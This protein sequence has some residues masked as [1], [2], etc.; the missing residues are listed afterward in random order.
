MLLYRKICFPYFLYHNILFFRVI[1][2]SYFHSCTA[3]EHFLFIPL[4]FA[5]TFIFPFLFLY[6]DMFNSGIFH[7]RCVILWRNISLPF[8]HFCPAIF[9][10]FIYVPEYFI[11]FP[12]PCLCISMFLYRHVYL[13]FLYSAWS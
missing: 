4:F 6:R 11:L 12:G 7:F 9:F 3:P 2:L 13:L 10:F 8:L 1:S 5:V